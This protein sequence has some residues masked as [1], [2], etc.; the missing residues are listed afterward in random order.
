MTM[1]PTDVIRSP[2]LEIASRI[3]EMETPVL[4]RELRRA[5]AVTAET[6]AYLGDVWR[7]LERRGEDLSA[8]RVGLGEYLPL[9]AAGQLAPE[10]MVNFTGRLQLL[11]AVRL[12]P[13]DK[14]RQLAAGATVTVIREDR[15]TGILTPNEVPAVNLTGEQIRLVFDSGRMRDVAEQVNMIESA[16]VAARRRR[17]LPASRH[18]RIHVDK[19]AKT[20]KIGRMVLPLQAVIDAL[21]EAD[22]LH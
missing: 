19:A 13:V 21:T 7:E 8:Y 9:V 22:V 3:I 11:R 16:R 14:Q 17:S 1:D 20:V 6:I 4:L 12:L 18:Y 2:R 10:A 5:L 15:E